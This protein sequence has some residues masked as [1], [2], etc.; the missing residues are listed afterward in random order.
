VLEI[1][2]QSTSLD[3]AD[4]ERF[5]GRARRVRDREKGWQSII[6]AEVS[7]REVFDLRRPFGSPLR[8][9]VDG[10]TLQQA[11]RARRPVV[12]RLLGGAA[13]GEFRT[14]IGVPVVSREGIQYVL[15][16]EIDAASWLDFLRS[17]PIAADATMT[18]LDQDGHII[19]RTLDNVRWVG[20]PAAPDLRERSAQGVLAAYRSTSLEGQ[21]IYSAHSRSTVS[22]W[23]MATGVPVA[24]VNGVLWKSTLATGGGVA[25]AIALASA[26]ALLLSRQVARPLSALARLSAALTG[27]SPPPPLE[28]GLR[29]SE[30]DEAARALHQA[31]A[32]RRVN[33]A[34]FEVLAELAP[35]GLFQT[36]GG[37]GYVYVNDQWSTITGIS[38]EEAAGGGW[39][40][41]LHPD[42]RER[43]SRHWDDAVKLQCEFSSEYRLRLAGGETRWVT[44]QARPVRDSRGAVVSHVGLITDT[45]EVKRAAERREELLERTRTARM[46]AES[47]S[48]AKDQF[49]GVVSHELRNPLNSI[50]LWLEVLR[51]RAGD[52]PQIARALEFIKRAAD[53]QTKLID[54][55]LDIARIESGK[56]RMEA[57]TV[58]LGP[59]LTAAQ[60]SVRLAVAAKAITL[61][62]KLDE[63]ALAVT[64]DSG[65]LQQVTSNLLSNAVKFTPKDGKVEVLLSRVGSHARV[66]VKDNGE[67][68]A[69]EF[70]PHIFERFRQADTS[71]SRTA[72]GLGLGLAIARQLVELHGGRIWAESPGKGKGATFFVELPLAPAIAVIVEPRERGDDKQMTVVQGLRLLVVEDEP[73]AREALAFLLRSAGARVAMASSAGE[74][75]DLLD[76]ERFD[77]MVSDIGMPGQDGYDLIRLLRLRPQERGGQ[78]PSIALTAYAG[79]HD[80]RRALSAGYQIHLAKP[81]KPSAL[82]RGISALVRSRHDDLSA[83]T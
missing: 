24:V 62:L 15:L 63:G 29:I 14:F 82:T 40:A 12:S 73:G 22:G 75:L 34:R 20:K 38:R 27:G 50:Q 26:L 60:D 71:S 49:L 23:T 11:I 66:I 36:D 7:G 25:V 77:V 3:T 8:E 80:E 64:G 35:A 39:V 5:Y 76:R 67:G 9:R 43:V 59:I 54:D 61:E 79:I 53:T 1:L 81:V 69:P 57:G 68:I 31:L 52:H 65:R 13:S 72:P 32:D 42:D 2:A 45:T 6:L 78:T 33:E 55:L 48:H 47:A 19:A 74:A 44:A 37:G 51:P 21:P 83:A 56:L 4:L 41:A 58:P 70:L 17:Y 30:V 28:P 18:L 46:A 16:A 10:A